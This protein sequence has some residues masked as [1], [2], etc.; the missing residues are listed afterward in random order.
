MILGCPG[1][2]APRPRSRA[3][4]SGPA[5]SA[6]SHHLP[7]APAPTAQ[8]GKHHHRPHVTNGSSGGSVT[9]PGSQVGESGC[10]RRP[11]DP[12]T[13]LSGQ[14]TWKRRIQTRAE[15]CALPHPAAKPKTPREELAF[16]L[17]SP[18]A[19][20]SKWQLSPCL[21]RL[22]RP[23]PVSML[24]YGLDICKVRCL[25]RTLRKGSAPPW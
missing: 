24:S 20:S 21:R 10:G 8:Q 15:T 6:D 13:A 16:I 25:P 11:S 14:F 18:P 9:R 4:C 7:A 12:R 1:R 5:L 22:H 3:R 23:P 19:V 17:R 2:A